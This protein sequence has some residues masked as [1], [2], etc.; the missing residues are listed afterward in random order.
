MH[1]RLHLKFNIYFSSMSQYTYMPQSYPYYNQAPSNEY[2]EQRRISMPLSHYGGQLEQQSFNENMMSQ[3]RS[4]SMADAMNFHQFQRN[5]QAA[6]PTHAPPGLTKQRSEN[7]NKP[8]FSQYRFSENSNSES[9][10]TQESYTEAAK[11]NKDF[12][13]M[14]LNKPRTKSITGK[15]MAATGELSC[16]SNSTIKEEE[17]DSE[18]DSD[19]ASNNKTQKIYQQDMMLKN[20]KQYFNTLLND[21]ELRNQKR[22]ESYQIP[23]ST[24]EEKKMFRSHMKSSAQVFVPKKKDSRTGSMPNI[25]H[26]MGASNSQM[27]FPQNQ[28]YYQ[29]GAQPNYPVMA[30]YNT[31]MM[32]GNSSH[33]SQN[34]EMYDTN[35]SS[36]MGGVGSLAPPMMNYNYEERRNSGTTGGSSNIKGKGQLSE[37]KSGSVRNKR[38]N[39][40]QGYNK[41]RR[42]SNTSNSSLVIPSNDKNIMDYKGQI[43]AFAKNQQGSK[44]LQRVLAKASPDVLDFIVVEVGDNIHELMTDS[45]GNYF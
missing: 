13:K 33:M 20:N 16:H 15:L 5:N 21:Q 37:L 25:M 44:Y 8:N 18:K 29:F 42:S 9:E 24:L 32:P 34:T 2:L 7:L 38:N 23:V 35:A 14:T 31:G 36:S 11:M 30:N 39:A 10:G 26:P 17:F 28:G 3:Y 43:V 4:N 12:A 1:S 40:N 41:I 22:R 19:N 45:Y 27:N 6:I